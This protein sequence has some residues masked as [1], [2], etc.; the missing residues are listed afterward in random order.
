M[1]TFA[2]LFEWRGQP[3]ESPGLLSLV[4]VMQYAEGLSDRQAA[5]AVGS[6][7][8]LEVCARLGNRCGSPPP[9]AVERL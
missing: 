2:E 5:E 7:D 1:K 9:F 6:R 4:I 8:R 3:A